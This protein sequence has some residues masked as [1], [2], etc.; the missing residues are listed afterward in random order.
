MGHRVE[1]ARLKAVADAGILFDEGPPLIELKDR[2]LSQLDLV[3]MDHVSELK[4]IGQQKRRIAVRRLL[5]IAQNTHL[6]SAGF[7]FTESLM[8]RLK[9]DGVDFTEVTLHVGQAT[10]LPVRTRDVRDHSVWPEYYSITTETV[11]KIRRT[12]EEGG[13]VVAVGTTVVRC[14][15]SAFQE[16]ENL[17][18]GE[19]WARLYIVPGFRF[20]VVD[21]LL[22]NFHLPGS[23]LLILVSSFAGREEIFRA[24]REAV[25]RE[26]RFFSYGDCMLIQ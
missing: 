14:L 5:D 25:R 22:T 1:K 6:G 20:R 10:F 19:G 4:L 21:A 13:R 9:R 18:P 26:Y 2:G 16:R 12:R 24:Y 23:S 8:N 7:H 3:L 17:E 11:E 15:E